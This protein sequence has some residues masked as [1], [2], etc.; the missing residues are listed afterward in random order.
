MLWGISIPHARFASEFG[1]DVECYVLDDATKTAVISQRGMGEAIG[2]S[3]RGE[4]LKGF[5]NSKQME[6]YIGRDLREKLE[7]PIIF[8]R[9]GAAAENE[10]SAR[11]SGVMLAARD[12][13]PF[14]PN[15]FA[16]GSLPSSAGTSSTSPVAGRHKRKTPD[17]ST[18]G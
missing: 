2:F 6:G 7:N 8:Q 17:L 9:V 10:I 16:A 15:A 11:R 12:A 1:L 18:G 5:A 13:P 4:R 3:R 14:L